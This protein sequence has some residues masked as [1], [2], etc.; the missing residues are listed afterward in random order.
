MPEPDNVSMNYRKVKKSSWEIWLADD[1]DATL[2]VE[3]LEQ[4]C[5][6]FSVFGG[7]VETSFKV[8]TLHD[9]GR[10]TIY[11]AELAGKKYCIKLFKDRRVLTQFRTYLGFSKGR[12]A[13]TNGLRAMH[14]H[15]PVPQTYAYV[16]RKPF[17]PSMVVMELLEEATQINLLIEDMLAQGSE[18]TCDPF[19]I[20][21]VDSF[22]KFTRDMHDKGVSH[23]DFS[24][25]N[26]LVSRQGEEISLKL[27][28]LED[29]VFSKNAKVF[30]ASIDHFD[31]R[32]AR[33]V[34][35]ATL[36]LYLQRFKALYGDQ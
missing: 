4:F 32:M 21:I 8:W 12:C 17:G 9:G 33:Y 3:M 24:P 25:R 30:Q 7:Q 31:V 16:E 18:L 11:G 28:D 29:V 10:A 36:N 2:S 6:G 14:Q 27:I 22:A 20:H 19:F 1:C 15:V 34:D 26:V 5:Q 13:F 23:N 35:S